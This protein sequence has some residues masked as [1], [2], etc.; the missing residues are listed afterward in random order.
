M[1]MPMRLPLS[2]D[3]YCGGFSGYVFLSCYVPAGKP[4]SRHPGVFAAIFAGAV[5]PRRR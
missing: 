1:E 4:R 5:A 3:K 2:V